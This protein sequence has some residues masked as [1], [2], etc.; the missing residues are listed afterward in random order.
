MS[1]SPSLTQ[2]CVDDEYAI[3]TDRSKRKKEFRICGAIIGV[4][5]KKKQILESIKTA[6]KV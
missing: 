4:N 5:Y 1:S 3:V 2:T 6:V